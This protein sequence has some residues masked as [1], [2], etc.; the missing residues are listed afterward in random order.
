MPATSTALLSL[1]QA[2]DLPHEPG[3]S[4]GQWRWSVRQRM[5]SVRDALID[6][7]DH[8]VDGWL[9]ARGGAAIRER[10]TLLNRLTA[11]GPAVLESPE[12]DQVRID[13]KRLLTDIA[14]HFQ[15]LHDLA[16]DEVEL[17]LGGS[18]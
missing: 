4:L 18:E 14:H 17:E 3:A 12:V 16:Y 8:P 10:N 13:M 2:L 6:E 15:R 1:Q 11:M 5:A 7:T 9:V